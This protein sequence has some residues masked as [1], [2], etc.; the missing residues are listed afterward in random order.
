MDIAALSMSMSQSKLMSDVS[1]AVL[2]KV[3]DT[4]TTQSDAVTK[5]MEQSVNPSLGANVDI[6][7]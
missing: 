2:D 7:V 1:V 4:V 5:M 3:M 6:L